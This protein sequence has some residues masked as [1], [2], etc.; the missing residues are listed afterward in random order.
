MVNSLSLGVRHPGMDEHPFHKMATHVNNAPPTL[1]K[2]RKL[3]KNKKKAWRASKVQDIE[4]FLDDERRQL[5]TG[6]VKWKAEI[7]FDMCCCF[8]VS[9]FD[10]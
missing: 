2:N 9:S 10:S 7:S 5:R 8:C 1:P 4:E 3:G 6:Y